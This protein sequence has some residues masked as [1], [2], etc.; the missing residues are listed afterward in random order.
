LIFDI[1]ILRN[2]KTYALF[3]TDLKNGSDAEWFIDTTGTLGQRNSYDSV[4]KLKAGEWHRIGISIKN[5]DLNNYYIDGDRV[6]TTEIKDI[7]GY[8][9]ISEKG[10]LLFADNNGEDNELDVADVKIFSKA[11]DD[12]EMKEL[13]GYGR[14][15][16]EIAPRDTVII[17]Y[18]QTP[19]ES[20]IYVCWHASNSPESLVKYGT[21]EKLENSQM[22]DVHIWKDSTT[23]HWVKLT[24]LEP[25]TIYYYQAISDTMKSTIYKFKTA[26]RVGEK[27]GHIRFAIF[28]DTRTL[29]TR[30]KD[31]ISSIREKATELYGDADIENNLNL[32]WCNGDIVHHGEILSEYKPQWFLPLS[33]VSSNVPIMVSIGDHERNADDYFHYMKYEDLAGPQGEYYYSFKYGRILFVAI[34]SPQPTQRQLVWL[35]NL[36]KE[37]EIDTTIDWVISF[38]HSP[39]R[40]EIWPNGNH[41][42]VQN[43]II[44]LLSKY[45]KADMLNYGHSHAYER[46]QVTN[47]NLRLLEN[48]GGGAGL[49]RWGMYSNQE[50]YPEIQ[51]TYDYWCY[52][53]VDID[54]A[55]KKY[56]AKSYSLGHIDKIRN[57][58]LFDSFFRDKANE[59]PPQTPVGKTEGS[60]ANPVKLSASAYIGNYK[61]LSSQFQ[62]TDEQG[63]YF[64]PVI[65]IKRD[66]E[67][68]Y[69]DSGAP[70]FIPI[71]KN[72]GIDLT[73]IS[74]EKNKLEAGKKYWW[75]V[76][77][78]DRNLQWSEWSD[79]VLIIQ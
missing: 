20:S 56:E 77:Y 68:I 16:V 71:D 53:L 11:L 70:D 51:K 50:D 22:G 72:A 44:P 29:P 60:V 75:H 9:S 17:P 6:V 63:N 46:G 24:N 45:S 4:D 2:S 54:I 78:R 13:G 79:E 42:Y 31:V 67:N 38:I 7:D 25:E 37:A 1:K 47:G 34:N 52:T 39:G 65:D 64:Y 8:Y 74:L 32:V 35:D 21:S 14:P 3:Q 61:I 10:L 40:S 41:R 57:N 58:E 66:F 23:W 62:I 5:D 19:T 48:G 27:T 28:G 33:Y 26:P 30:F 36:L 59:T 49:D 69:S 12:S 76:R 18:L 15:P 43:K 55:N 73:K